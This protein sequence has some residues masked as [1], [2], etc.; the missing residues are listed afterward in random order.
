MDWLPG[1]I[2]STLGLGEVAV[3]LGIACLL[4]GVIGIE[5]ERKE[6]PAGLRTYMLTGLAAAL[7]T[8]I[9]VEMSLAFSAA[10]EGIR[11]D[12]IRIIEAVTAGVAFLAAGTIIIRKGDV[13][14]L[15][16][17]AG[18]WMS[19]AIGV[20]CGAGYYAIAVMAAAL[21]LVIFVVVRIF[22]KSLPKKE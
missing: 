22:E 15:T 18:M 2:E 6:R 19:G 13:S 7:F 4:C 1:N 16:T 11:S 17:G 5:R 3:R 20:A 21:G 8:V 12:P 14:G 10:G 9:T